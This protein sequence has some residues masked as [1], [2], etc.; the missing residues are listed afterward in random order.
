MAVGYQLLHLVEQLSLRAIVIADDVG[1]ALAH[2]GDRDL[3]GMLA[4]SAMWSEFAST[5]IDDMTLV[6][7]QQRYPDIELEHVASGSLGTE[8]TTVLAVGTHTTSRA[9][10]RRA[11]DGIAR[12]CATTTDSGPVFL[13]PEDCAASP[14]SA[15]ATA[16][17]NGVLWAIG[18]CR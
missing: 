11:L 6:Q 15:P 5:S 13:A 3:S 16:R 14:P 10:I 4:D 12:I 1:I 7:I 8:G 2:A 9:A 18:A 17:E